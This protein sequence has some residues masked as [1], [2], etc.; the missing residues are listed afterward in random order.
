MAAARR[1]GGACR[2]GSAATGDAGGAASRDDLPFELYELP[3]HVVQQATRGDCLGGRRPCRRVLCRYH[4][5][6]DFWP[7]PDGWIR[8]RV[9]SLEPGQPSCALDIADQGPQLHERIGE[10]LGC[11]EAAVRQCLEGT[12]AKFR[13]DPRLRQL[14]E[15]MSQDSDSPGL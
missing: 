11:T 8:V 12:F 13:R 14:A 5:A 2:D 4:L 1:A 9:R 3:D 15:W 10:I 7:L 6:T